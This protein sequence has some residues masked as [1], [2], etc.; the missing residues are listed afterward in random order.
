MRGRWHRAVGPRRDHHHPAFD[1]EGW[2]SCTGDRQC[3]SA[4]AQSLQRHAR[5]LWRRDHDFTG[6]SGLFSIVLKPVPQKAFDAL[7]DAV[8]LLGMGYSWGGFESLK[9]DLD[10]GFAAL[11]AAA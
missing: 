6:V 2:R 10:R 5:P 11:K 7:L 4:V 1:A 8:K 3:L 9:A